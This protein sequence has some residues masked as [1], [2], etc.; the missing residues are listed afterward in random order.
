MNGK[1]ILCNKIF[2]EKSI[3]G[4]AFFRQFGYSSLYGQI[5]STCTFSAPNGSNDTG[6]MSLSCPGAESIAVQRVKTNIWIYYNI[7]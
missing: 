6:F 1:N 2:P 3:N 7:R 4:V 5:F